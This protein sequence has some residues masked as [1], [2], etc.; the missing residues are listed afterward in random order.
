MMLVDGRAQETVSANDR[1][2]HFGDGVFETMAV[3]DGRALCLA[4]HLERLGA[5]CT[6]LAIPAP[7]M[8]T[9]E[10]ECAQL[11]LGVAQGVLKIIVTRGPSG[12]GYAPH[13]AAT[14]TRVVAR[15]PWP[16]YPAARRREGVA[17]RVCATRLARN[18]ALA[19]LKHLNR[20]EQVLARAEPDTQEYPEGLMLDDTGQVIEG[21]MS[22]VFMR[23]GK[24]LS[25]PDLRQCG[26]A[27]IMRDLILAAVD[28]LH[29]ARV[30][31]APLT[32]EDL[33]TADECFLCNSLIGIWPIQ[34][35]HGTPLGVGPMAHELQTILIEQ[36]AI[37]RE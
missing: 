4:R 14:A 17:V 2:L 8:S 25:T 37:T 10:S 18:R 26:V 11:A 34:S 9:L 5:G 21:T 15:Y 19:G 1:G 16:D 20:L 31:V 24:R 33:M 23:R 3:E 36:G 27:G 7:A 13:P 32:V 35:L 6:R 12:R 28:G 29:G 30:D 22:N